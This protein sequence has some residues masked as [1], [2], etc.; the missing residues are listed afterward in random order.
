MCVLWSLRV[1]E[2]KILSLFLFLSL[3]EVA[4]LKITY[5]LGGVS[6]KRTWEG[7]TKFLDFGRTYFFNAPKVVSAKLQVWVVAQILTGKIIGN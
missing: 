4:K 6:Q 5:V 3:E 2:L 1:K 7:S